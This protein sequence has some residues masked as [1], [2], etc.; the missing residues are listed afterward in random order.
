M[1]A[2]VPLRI[3]QEIQDLRLNG[4]VQSGNR[5]VTFSC[6]AL[7]SRSV[8]IYNETGRTWR[9][10]NEADGAEP[11]G[12]RGAQAGPQAKRDTDR[13]TRERNRTKSTMLCRETAGGRTM[14]R[15]ISLAMVLTLM[16][17]LGSTALAAP[18][19]RDVNPGSW[20]YNEV[21]EM[22]S[23][24]AIEG[25]EDGTFQPDRQVSVV[26]AVTMAAR[27]VGAP[28]GKNE[29]HWGG[30][31]MEHA[32]ASGWI[33]EGDVARN[34]YG[35]L[36]S[37]ELACKIIASA[38][39][40]EAVEGAELSF[41]DAAS[42]SESYLAS[43]LA[44]CSSGLLTGYEDNTLRPQ[45][46]LTRAQA[47]ALL[48]RAAHL[49]EPAADSSLIRAAGY[50]KQQ[51]V[52]Y[53]LEVGVGSMYGDKGQSVKWGAPIRYYVK[54][55]PTQADTERVET[56][57]AALN[58]VPNCPGIS[59]AESESEATLMIYFESAEAVN[60][61]FA[62]Y[63]KLDPGESGISGFAYFSE[64][65]MTSC[66]VYISSEATQ[67]TRDFV[68]LTNL[69]C[70]VGLF[71]S[72]TKYADSVFYRGEMSE[73]Q[74]FPTWPST[75]DWALVQLVFSD[76]VRAG[77]GASTARSVVQKLVA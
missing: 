34:E 13:T 58:G 31:Q 4:H 64:N 40:L 70:S 15:I 46:I 65:P 23:S 35:K 19:L 5:L 28:T 69:F 47:A 77:M 62:E 26:E 16:L 72:S 67:T 54:G 22:V 59:K 20:F 24:G 21:S 44:M 56:I 63:L 29:A 39:G 50:T 60:E 11:H 30:I 68:I 55:S 3:D 32:Y 45:S 14:K 53:Y 37:R 6:K 9:A 43:V 41:T 71:N 61:A 17:S 76:S 74:T 33:S 1:S 75:L 12:E 52:D 36:V 25:Y 66:K 48:Y 73:G 8:L 27:M 18:S 57:I 49:G 10:G 2:R 38:L 42:V 51:I 7:D